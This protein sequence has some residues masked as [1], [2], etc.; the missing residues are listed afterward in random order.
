MCTEVSGSLGLGLRL[1]Q[2]YC[3][4]RGA[5]AEDNSCHKVLQAVNGQ[6]R[7][8]SGR[9]IVSTNVASIRG[10]KKAAAFLRQS[11]WHPNKHKSIYPSATCVEESRIEAAPN[12]CTSG[13]CS[14]CSS[15]RREV[16]S[17][18]NKS[19]YIVVGICAF[20]CILL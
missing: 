2:Q 1:W 18:M 3:R 14:K 19:H 8:G 10:A 5:A 11:I 16:W 17:Y 9:Y 4:V 7:Q 13:H 20:C 15:G 6:D 12:L